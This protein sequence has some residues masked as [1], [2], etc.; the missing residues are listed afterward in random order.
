MARAGTGDEIAAAVAHT[1]GCERRDQQSVHDLIGRFFA[2]HRT[3][4]VSWW[5]P[6]SD[7]S[8]PESHRA[9]LNTAP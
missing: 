7:A 6:S 1:P 2:K 3:P 9:A 8:S 4:L 5:R